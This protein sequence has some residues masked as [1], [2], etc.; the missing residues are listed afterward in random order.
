MS[1]CSGRTTGLFKAPN[2]SPFWAAGFAPSVKSVALGDPGINAFCVI[3][4]DMITFRGSVEATAFT[5]KV[6][7][8]DFRLEVAI[9]SENVEHD[10]LAWNHAF[11][12]RDRIELFEQA[13]SVN[14]GDKMG[15]MAARPCTSLV[16]RKRL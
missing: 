12:P 4:S 3:V 2:S 8:I 6:G 16:K 1:H 14:G 9:F 10:P 15:Q 7:Y 13:C 5:Q 11:V